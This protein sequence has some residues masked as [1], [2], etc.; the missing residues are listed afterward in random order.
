MVHNPYNPI[1]VKMKTIGLVGGLSYQSTVEYYRIINNE[2]NARFGGHHSCPC[3]VYSLDFEP[4]LH[5]LELGAW[6][7]LSDIIARAVQNLVKAG[8]ELIMIGS[9]TN[10]KVVER[11]Q[12]KTGISILHIADATAEKILEMNLDTVALLGTKFTMEDDFYTGR[13]QKLGIHTLVPNALERQL[14]HGIIYDE[15]D[16]N[17]IKEESRRE[18]QK[19]IRRLAKEGA[20]GV[21]LGCTEIPLL[22]SQKDCDIPVF[23]TTRLH[24]LAG[25]EK[26][27]AP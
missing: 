2:V 26:A 4:T 14:V 7:K 15:L 3:I 19:I 10:N 13:L 24:A 16:F 17:L 12:E 20:Q 5:L 25:V 21:I 11:V 23:D 9:N 18:Y 22:I 6:D 27:L 8:A 1:G